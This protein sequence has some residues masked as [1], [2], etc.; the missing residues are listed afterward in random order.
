MQI[1]SSFPS[2]T[3]LLVAIALV[4]AAHIFAQSASEQQEIVKLDRYEVTGSKI[5]LPTGALPITTVTAEDITR[6]GVS[7]NLLEALRKQIPAFSGGGNIGATN[8]GTG[9]TST[10]GGSRLSLHNMPTLVLLNGRRV[11]T[12]GASARGGSNFVDV[13]MF[14][15]SAI[16]RVE[17]VSDGASAIYG[18]DAIGG[19]VNIILKQNFNGSEFGGRYAFSKNEGAYSERSAWLTSGVSDGRIS[20]V[21][22][23]NY[24][25]VRPLMLGDRPFSDVAMTGGYSGVVGTSYLNPALNSPSDTVPV[26]TAA[27]AA[28]MAA[29]V[30]NGTYTTTATTINL[31]DDVTLLAG[32]EQSSFAGNVSVKLLDRHLT[33]FGDFVFTK[34]ESRTQLG[35]QVVTTLSAPAGSPYNPTTGEVRSINFRY[36]PAPREYLNDSQGLRFTAGLKGEITPQWDWQ[37]AYTYSRNKLVARI[38]NVLYAPNLTFAINGNYDQNGNIVPGGTYSR[39]V[40]GFNGASTDFVIQPALDPFARASAINPASLVNIL[41]VARSEFT[42]ILDSGDFLVHGR[43]F[44]L[45]AGDIDIVFGG[46]YRTELLKGVPDENSRQSGDTANRWSGGSAFDPFDQ[47]RNVRS[48]FT[49]VR[50]PIAGP[51]K[52]VAFVRAL[53]VMAAYRAENYSD[54]GTSKVPKFG[55]R[56]QPL[57]EQ[58]TVRGTYSEGF[59]APALYALYGPT[60]QG[61]SAN[62]SP[63][64]GY[65]SGTRQA[66]LQTKS[67]EF[68]KPTSS[69][70]RSVGFVVVPKLLPGFHFSVDYLDTEIEGLIGSAG[71]LA[72][73]HSVNLLGSASPYASQVTLDGAAITTPGQVRSYLDTAGAT[74]SRILI[75]DQRKNYT[76]AILR[77]LDV[78]AGYT[79]KSKACG[80]VEFNTTGTFFL[81]DKIQS[82][83]TERHYEYAG[84]ATNFEG[85]MPGYRFHSSLTWR[86]AAWEVMIANDYV[87]PV[88]DIGTGGWTYDTSTTLRRIRI[89][90]FTSWDF[91]LSYRLNLKK[92]GSAGNPRELA[93]RVGV[94]NVFNE[95][96]PP[97]PQAFPITTLSGADVA[98]YGVVGRLYYVSASLQF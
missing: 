97:A 87:A 94:N 12:N 32:R 28:N 16:E 95:L 35:A 63:I 96:P 74:A 45:P 76:S 41:G 20:V 4:G 44:A 11:A 59:A 36:L 85:T 52:N 13:S 91:G 1:P 82:V 15:L 78:N 93:L 58:V 19:V 90:S 79:L 71:A 3:A 7:S 54:V 53:E 25:K 50:V 89:P 56:W 64:L 34:A 21:V 51:K 29:L 31:A 61:F 5:A 86:R 9:V 49:E 84:H 55:V 70:S 75:V 47:K 33:A 62:L 8:A 37:A 27:T 14:P 17:V 10:Y 77:S 83:P 24:S 81:D 6:G 67:N 80:E 60:I 68:L 66:T 46:D 98:T 40:T 22:S 88:E 57:S 39:V 92:T 73:I 65:A 48:V 43:P 42:S 2:R 38:T 26:G 69:K 23:G 18:S 30:A 72:I